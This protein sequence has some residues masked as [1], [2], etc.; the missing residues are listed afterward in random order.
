[1]K[2]HRLRSLLRAF[3]GCGAALLVLGLSAGPAY[4]D[5]TQ[6]NS[7][8][9]PHVALIQTG[10]IDDPLE[11]VLEHMAILGATYVFD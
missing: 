10:Q 1:V 6:S 9:A 8:N 11:D 3:A 7:H 4:A 2:S 5:E